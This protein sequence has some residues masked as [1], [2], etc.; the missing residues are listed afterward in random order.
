M[1][2]T[3]LKGPKRHLRAS[4][5]RGLAQLATQATTGATRLVEGVHQSVRST[6]SLTAGEE[7][8]Q[9]GGIPGVVYR[10]FRRSRE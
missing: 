10:A 6:L 8:G 5:L 7:P 4:D 1:T 9:T 2:T 3:D